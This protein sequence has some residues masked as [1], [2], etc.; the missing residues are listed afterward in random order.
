M[1][2]EEAADEV[3]AASESPLVSGQPEEGRSPQ[4]ED[5]KIT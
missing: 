4:E 3:Y 1:L 5:Q 2:K